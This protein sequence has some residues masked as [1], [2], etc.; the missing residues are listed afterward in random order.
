[1]HHGRRL[2]SDLI[3][4]GMVGLP[5]DGWLMSADRRPTE[6]AGE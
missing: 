5:W 6:H 1:M 4:T 2:P 3:G